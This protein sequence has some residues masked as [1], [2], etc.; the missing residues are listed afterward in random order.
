MRA[1][2]RPHP[3]RIPPRR[4]P[5]LAALLVA[6]LALASCSS[7]SSSGQP[8]SAEEASAGAVDLSEG[9][10]WRS[11]PGP[12]ELGVTHTRNSLDDTE[13]TEAR[14]RGTQILGGEGPELQNHHLMG[15][16]TLNPE[17]AQGQYDWSSLDRRM[18]LTKETDG[19]PMLTLCCAPDWMKG[20]E[21]G[22]TDWSKLEQAPSPEHYGDYA[23]LAA[24]AVKRY[25]QVERV[26]VWNELKGFYNDDDN[27][28]DY[29]AYTDLYNQV[30]KAVKAARPDV[31]VGGPYVV[32]N[33][34]P[35]GSPDASDV[36]GPWGAL[37]QRPLDVLDYWLKHN[38]GADFV[39]VDGSTTNKGV[40][41]AISPVDVGAQ[42]FAVVDDW[43]KQ[44]TRMP[45]WW[46]EFYAN[47]PA[48]ADAGYDQEA[49]A[50]STLAALSAMARSG[51]GG[52]LLWGPE[53]SDDLKYSSLW[54]PATESDGGQP[55]PLTEAWKWLVPRLE[56]GGVEFGRSQ[57]SPLTAFRDAD[58]NVLMVN[59]SADPVPVPG[60]Q[61]LPGW[62]IVQVSKGA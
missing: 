52:A 47:V 49:S 39:V 18:E 27:R 33:S 4:V 22:D 7:G 10:V 16:G 46:A 26:Q 53:G 40:Q 38:V 43:I 58:G 35:A 19:T 29:E 44:R 8:S 25:P 31:R 3:A 59:L 56:E 57:G 17:P 24:A 2:S 15:F 37:D 12:M 28:W 34:V 6:L 23:E 51:A 32:T 54:T 20:G 36:T 9:W 21:P 60:E 30:Y 11:Q 62:A 50:V 13:P 61:P 14:R 55:T 5:A 41:D 45:V 1:R 48:G 42:K